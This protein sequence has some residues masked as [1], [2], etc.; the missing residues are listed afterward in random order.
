MHSHLTP[1]CFVRSLSLSHVHSWLVA[2]G[3]LKAQRL[4]RRLNTQVTIKGLAK[5]LRATASQITSKVRHASRAS[6]TKDLLPGLEQHVATRE[7]DMARRVSHQW[8][9]STSSRESGA[10][11]AFGVSGPE[12]TV[13]RIDVEAAMPESFAMSDLH[14]PETLVS[15]VQH[16]WK[17]LGNGGEVSLPLQVAKTSLDSNHLTATE[18]VLEVCGCVCGVW[19]SAWRLAGFV[20]LRLLPCVRD[21]DVCFV[22]MLPTQASKG[23][24]H[25]RDDY[26]D[27]LMQFGCVCLRCMCGTMSTRWPHPAMHFMWWACVCTTSYVCMFTT[28]WALAPVPAFINNVLEIRGDTFK[29]FY[30]T[31]RPVPAM[32]PG[33]GEWY[34]QFHRSAQW[35][36]PVVVALIML[37]TGEVRT[38]VMPSSLS[39]TLPSPHTCVCAMWGDGCGD[40]CGCQLVL[41]REGGREGGTHSHEHV[42]LWY[43]G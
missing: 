30:S 8:K 21:T 15:A 1:P 23:E 24:F 38:A 14:T 5:N 25:P 9:E 32:D 13:S 36:I 17:S 43:S 34:H 28:V 42:W 27:M 12:S 2:R 31:R 40:G 26:L 3:M 39:F 29:L 41:R 10:K 35:A 37:T 33:I 11:K 7:A 18:V 22:C 6:A 19:T 20:F 16:S 4:K